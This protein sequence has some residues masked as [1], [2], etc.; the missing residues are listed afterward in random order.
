MYNTLISNETLWQSTA[1]IVTY[2][3]HGGFFDHV[4]PPDAPVTAGGAGFQT[5]GVRVPAFVISP[6]V[7]PGSV[8]SEAVDS[9]SILQ[10][11]A[12]R[13]TPGSAYSEAVQARQA[14]FRPLGAVLDNPRTA[15]RPAPIPQNVLDQLSHGAPAARVDTGEP[16]ETAKAFNRAVTAMAKLHPD[17]FIDQFPPGTV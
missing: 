13:F 12:D 14:Y 7:K 15:A 1:L 2:D 6:Y 4:Q 5:S 17:Q 9:T 3:E 10:M 16:T 11:L 8:F